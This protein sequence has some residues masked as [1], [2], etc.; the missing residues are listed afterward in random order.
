M[1][2]VSLGR[3]RAHGTRPR[4]GGGACVTRGGKRVLNCMLVWTLYHR[5]LGR[6]IACLLRGF[7]LAGARQ[8]QRQRQKHKDGS[9]STSCYRSCR[10]RMGF[11]GQLG[12]RQIKLLA[13]GRT[14]S[15]RLRVVCPARNRQ[16]ESA[17]GPPANCRLPE[18][19]RQSGERAGR[20]RQV[21][22][23]RHARDA[24]K[25]HK[26]SR[27]F[28]LGIIAARYFC[29]FCGFRNGSFIGQRK[30]RP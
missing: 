18:D 25:P 15:R 8:S 3:D 21:V 10:R 27:V 20:R 17:E 6:F 4:G 12:S 30:L 2:S 14:E 5:S 9:R 16:V 11:L 28:R 24:K 1:V 29:P 19:L 23:R 26:A 13:R 22:S 7:D